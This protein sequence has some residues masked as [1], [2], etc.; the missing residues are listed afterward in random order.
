MYRRFGKNARRK[1]SSEW[2]RSRD[3]CLVARLFRSANVKFYSSSEAS[4][5]L[6]NQVKERRDVSVDKRISI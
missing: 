3:V 5:T 1:A 4:A 2:L 6:F